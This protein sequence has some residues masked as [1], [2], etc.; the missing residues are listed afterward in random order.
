MNTD[1]YNRQIILP[2]I[3]G[4]GQRRLTTAKVLVVGAGGLGCPVLQYLAAAGIG[5]L[6]IIDHDRI[7][8]TNLQRQI[9]FNTS[10]AGQPKAQI[11]QNRLQAL[12]PDIT[13][14]AYPEELSDRNASELFAAYDV[15][16]DCTDNFSAK[17]LINDVAV[18]LGKAVVYGAIQGFEG[19]VAV[20]DAAQG[21]CYRCLHPRPPRGV[22]L[23]CAESGVIGALA[24]M[25]GTIQAMEVIKLI[26]GHESFQSLYGNL[27][28][29][30]S[31]T[32]EVSHLTIPKSGN[33]PVCSLSAAEIVP[34]YTSPVCFSA[35]VREIDNSDLP[36]LSGCVMI[37]V[38]EHEEWDQGHIPE[39]LH[40]PLS[41]LNRDP[42]IFKP[43][44]HDSCVLYCQRGLR[45][46][47][48][49]E[50]L[51]QAGFSDIYS[52]KGGYEAWLLTKS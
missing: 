22:I 8:I 32:M 21:P 5:L 2:E 45:S 46:Q 44:R 43:Y 52:L 35:I 28:I 18:K 25:I 40:L 47:K 11:A 14:K 16:V 17:F 15:I 30:D 19:Q 42:E 1:R 51:L 37:D 12:N 38:R 10:D 13:I 27:L 23:N 36:T 34:H 9:L 41:A 20:F 50:I 48:A 39:A 24:G 29:I 26:I 31:K 6:G 4:E 49:A 3:G 33:C 7:D